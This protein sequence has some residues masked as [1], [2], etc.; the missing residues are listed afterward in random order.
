MPSTTCS[1]PGWG[2]EEWGQLSLT[3]PRTLPLPAL[4]PRLTHL[5]R[6]RVEVTSAVGSADEFALVPWGDARVLGHPGHG[7]AEPVRATVVAV[8]G[9]ALLLPETLARGWGG[10]THAGS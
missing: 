3:L 4:L 8:E 1:G 6:Q 7:Q 5:R 10:G 9:L 2:E